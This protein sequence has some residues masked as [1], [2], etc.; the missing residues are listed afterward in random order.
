M[1]LTISF[2]EVNWLANH[3]TPYFIPQVMAITINQVYYKTIVTFAM[4][5]LDMW[6]LAM[7]ISAVYTWLRDQ[8]Q[9]DYH[10][11]K[12]ITY[13]ED[14]GLSPTLSKML[15]EYTNLLWRKHK[16]I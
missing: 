3:Y 13:L 10:V 4:Y 16:G 9:Y 15:Q 7:A 6:L 5:I 11:G 1:P 8:N 12:L 14:S 2:D